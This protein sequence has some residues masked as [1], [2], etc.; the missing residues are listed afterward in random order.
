MQKKNFEY[1]KIFHSLSLFPLGKFFQ[2]FSAF[3]GT[4]SFKTLTL[5]SMP[6]PLIFLAHADTTK[7]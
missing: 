4:D 7:S 6:K 2:Q 3:V 1:I 5:L